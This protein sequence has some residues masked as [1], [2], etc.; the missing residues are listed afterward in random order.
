VELPPMI[1]KTTTPFSNEWG[2]LL[3]IIQNR[4]KHVK[5]ILAVICLMV[6]YLKANAQKDSTTKWTTSISQLGGKESKISDITGH[7]LIK[8]DIEI[9]PFYYMYSSN[10]DKKYTI[11]TSFKIH[12]N[13]DVII[14]EPP[15]ETADI[16]RIKNG[17]HTINVYR[18]GAQY[19]IPISLSRPTSLIYT[20][21]Y[22]TF[23]DFGEPT[24]IMR[25]KF[26]VELNNLYCIARSS[27]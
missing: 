1:Q 9:A 25:R 8:I 3:Q 26:I 27:N 18:N 20:V 16:I 6:V 14:L 21:T 24:P 7:Y 10:N 22:N 4:M 23:S 19:T 12:E 13:P 17:E 11:P 15:I 5:T 2:F